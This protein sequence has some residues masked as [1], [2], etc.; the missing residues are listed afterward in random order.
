MS[1]SAILLRVFTALVGRNCIN[2]R[3]ARAF[4]CYA[5]EEFS[6]AESFSMNRPPHVALVIETSN[7]FARGL[8]RGICRYA[9]KFGPWSIQHHEHGRSAAPPPWLKRW[10]GDGIIARIETEAIARRVTALG[11]PAVNVGAARLLPNLPCMGTDDAAIARL[12]VDHFLERGFRHFGYCGV[13]GFSWSQ[14]RGE[15]FC[16]LLAA[17]RYS[18]S[19][20]EWAAAAKSADPWRL[21]RPSVLRWLRRLPRPAAVLAAW[22]GCAIE[23]LSICRQLALPV[24]EEIAVLGIDDDDLLCDLSDPPLSSVNVDAPQVGYQAA[25]LLH[26]LMLGKKV[27]GG[28][29]LTPPRA[30]STRRSTD[31]L[32]VADADV[33]QALNFI[34][35][36][37]CSGINVHDVLARL[38]LSR[39]VLEDRF[40][41]A[42]GRTPHE[43]IVRLQIEQ[44]KE[45]LTETDL[46]MKAIADRA[47][48]RHVEYLSVVF[49]KKVGQ[50]P[51]H[52]RSRQSAGQKRP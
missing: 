31:I 42:V 52:Y 16:R 48:F 38:S 19:V 26:R 1:F 4:R 20:C 3:Q 5:H 13:A 51:S 30:V 17:A 15:H 37:A 10:Q 24:P 18:C 28:I 40:K 25:G 46:S 34:R 12:A 6:E 29:H 7:G 32:A 23:L 2:W 35:S 14:W 9:R 41:K 8:L 27:P 45:L 22:D 44:V 33:A 36:Q 49:K 21:D 50:A 43:E 39:R 47:G 11:V